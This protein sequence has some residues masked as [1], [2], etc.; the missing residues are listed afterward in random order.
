M[1]M[2]NRMLQRRNN[3]ISSDPTTNSCVPRKGNDVKKF[4]SRLC[5]LYLDI[6][7]EEVEQTVF[8]TSLFTGYHTESDSYI[9]GHKKRS[10]VGRDK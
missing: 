8:K 7:S 2:F 4:A 9:K 1:K 10:K 3:L 5:V 6:I